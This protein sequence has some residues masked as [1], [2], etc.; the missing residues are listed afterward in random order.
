MAKRGENT[1]PDAEQEAAPAN[2]DKWRSMLEDLKKNQGGGP[3]FYIKEGRTQFHLIGENGTDDFFVEVIETHFDK[4]KP[5]YI[6]MGVILK[7][8]AELREQFQN[9]VVPI[10]VPKTVFS[11]II[12]LLAEGYNLTDVEEGHG[13][14]IRRSGSG[15]NTEYSVTAS[16]RPVVLDIDNI[17]P[18]DHLLD[19]LPAL[20]AARQTSGPKGNGDDEKGD[21]G[22]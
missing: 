14:T 9:K 8:D 15:L 17:K 21:P 13:L 5:K 11:G 4:P 6:V 16:P 12:E 1:Q 19:E 10:V 2:S 7:T 20:Y 3:F 18:A 22:W